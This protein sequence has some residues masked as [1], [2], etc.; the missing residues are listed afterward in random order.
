MRAHVRDQRVGVAAVN[1]IP[2]QTELPSNIFKD[3][4]NAGCSSP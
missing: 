4:V 2:C 3:V 1:D